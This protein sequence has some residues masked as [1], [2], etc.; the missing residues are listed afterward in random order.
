MRAKW[1]RRSLIVP[2]IALFVTVGCAGGST[3]NAGSVK[4]IAEWASTEQANFLSVL[5]PFEDSTGI[6]VQYESTRDLSAVLRTRVAAGNPP[7]LAAAPN[8]QLLTQFAQQGKVIALDDKIDMSQLKQNYSQSWIDLGT[9]NGKLYQVYSWVSLKGLIWYNVKAFQA[10]SYT[11]PKTFDDMAAL[12]SQIKGTGTTPWCVALKSG[13]ADDGWPGSDW[14]KEIVLSQSGP[15]VYDKWVAGT[16][17][18]S[19]P[20]IKAAFTTWGKVLGPGDDSN[21]FG[22]SK[23]ITNTSFKTG[24]NPLF[25]NPPKCY[26]HNQASFITTFFQEA[27]P[28]LQPVTDF[29]F[30]PLPDITAS[31]AG[32]HVVSGDAWSMFHDSPQTRKLLNYLTTANAQVIWVKKGG[33][34]S[35]NKQTPL[36]SYPDPIS[37]ESAQI[38]VD[39]KIGKYDATDLMPADMRSAAWK[40][41][42]DFVTN[43]GK[44]DSI[45][46]TLDQVQATAYKS[47]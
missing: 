17:K 41:C 14:P 39:T 25:T 21:V 24:G 6:K 32:A 11:V 30:F 28:N 35:P 36:D 1:Y 16:Q 42:L 26:L 15:D 13:G 2:L 7:D 22:G 31:Y 20:E 47:S 9:I 45:L 19:S 46:A 43:Q 5:K 27:N 10:K 23:G 40:A 18:W 29:N 4:V 34:I 44:L 8:P 33:K 37:K 12:Q 3:Q 38:L